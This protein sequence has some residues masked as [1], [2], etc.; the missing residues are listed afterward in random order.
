MILLRQRCVVLYGRGVADIVNTVLYRKICVSVLG[1]NA[2]VLWMFK[3]RCPIYVVRGNL[4][5]LL[6]ELFP[7]ELRMYGRER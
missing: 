6:V 1:S 2:V 3:A 5:M 7:V 4:P